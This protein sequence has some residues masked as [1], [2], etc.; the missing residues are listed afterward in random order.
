M[1]SL[2]LV[3][4]FW[5]K[6]APQARGYRLGLRHKTGH[7][8]SSSQR[9]LAVKTESVCSSECQVLGFGTSFRYRSRRSFR[10]RIFALPLASADLLVMV[11]VI[12]ITERRNRMTYTKSHPRDA[13]SCRKQARTSGVAFGRRGRSLRASPRAIRGVFCQG[14]TGQRSFGEASYQKTQ[15]S[16]KDVPGGRFRLPSGAI[17]LRHGKTMH[18]T[19]TEMKN[20]AQS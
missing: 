14:H 19:A 12:D 18:S 4:G 6:P 20:S 9:L 8:P 2:S 7:A 1:P 10:Y 15:L 16:P 11:G 5:V 3:Q 13:A 17:V